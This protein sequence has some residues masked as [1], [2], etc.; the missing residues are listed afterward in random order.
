MTR[1]EAGYGTRVIVISTVTGGG[2]V[3]VGVDGSAV[4]VAVGAPV[5]ASVGVAVGARVGVISVAVAVG[6][7]RVGDGVVLGVPV[8]L[9]VA[10]MLAVAVGVLVPVAPSVAVSSGARVVGTNWSGVA[11]KVAVGP[12]VLVGNSVPTGSGGSVAVGVSGVTPGASVAEAVAV[13][14]SAGRT[15]GSGASASA[16]KPAQ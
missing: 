8:P 3:A 16:A 12:R 4:T 11:C 2:S 5:G 6:V 15:T 9:G 14:N 10:V 1:S 7:R 13:I